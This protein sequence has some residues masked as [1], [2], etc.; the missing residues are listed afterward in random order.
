MSQQVV[1]TAVCQCSFGT[2]PTPLNVLP[3]H[4][5]LVS[6]Q[7]AANITDFAP[8]MNITPFAMCNS[9]ANPAVI[10]ATAASFGAPTP[11]PCTPATASP[12]IV[13]A[14]T[15]LLGNMPALNSTSKL[16]CSFGGVI[17][18]VFPGQV[19]VQLP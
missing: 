3:T 5:A 17:Q 10:A 4:Q 19:T 11:A 9:K 12:W 1:N 13:G 15:V 2:A 16:M 18:I 8:F 6:N 14:P 7:P